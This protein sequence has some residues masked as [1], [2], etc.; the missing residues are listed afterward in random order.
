L[1]P[2]RIAGPHVVLREVRP[3]DTPAIFCYASDPAVVSPVVL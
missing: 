3:D 2:V 1:Y